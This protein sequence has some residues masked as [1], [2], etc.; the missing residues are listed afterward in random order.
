[1]ESGGGAIRRGADRH[2]PLMKTGDIAILPVHRIAD[3]N[4][5]LYMWS[6]NNHLPDALKVMESWGFRYVTLRSGTAEPD[7]G[8]N[9]QRNPPLPAPIG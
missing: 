5:H 2:Y 4:C 3:T 1:M 8:I 6:T 7:V 9:P